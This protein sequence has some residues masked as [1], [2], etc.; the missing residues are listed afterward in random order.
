MRTRFA[1]AR[2]T[3]D[4]TRARC[5]PSS[6]GQR[7]RSRRSRSRVG[8]HPARG[9]ARAPRRAGSVTRSSSPAPSRRAPARVLA[10][11]SDIATSAVRREECAARRA[12]RAPRCRPKPRSLRR[13]AQPGHVQRR[14][15][16][17][18]CSCGR[19]R[20]YFQQRRRKGSSVGSERAANEDSPATGPRC[21]RAGGSVA[22]GE[23]TLRRLARTGGAARV[24]ASRVPV[25][26]RKSRDA[27]VVAAAR[28]AG[29][30]WAR[31]AAFSPWEGIQ[32]ASVVRYRCAPI[33]EVGVDEDHATLAA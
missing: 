23:N 10:F 7:A 14:Q 28:P 1:S 24:A 3:A 20:R 13:A 19:A 2:S 29:P 27:P 30:A 21:A 32:N 16:R 11:A 17:H 9:A 12:G 15:L 25:R 26:L 33:W 6:T 22:P 18:G 31:L 5:C 8:D 4:R